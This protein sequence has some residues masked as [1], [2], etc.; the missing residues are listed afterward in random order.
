[1]LFLIL[2]LLSPLR[3]VGERNPDKIR[4]TLKAENYAINKYL[5]YNKTEKLPFV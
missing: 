1:M 2:Q 3:K 4:K 5:I